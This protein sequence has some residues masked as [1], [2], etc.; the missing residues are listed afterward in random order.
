MKELRAYQQSEA[1]KMCAEKIQEKKIKKGESAGGRL[2][3]YCSVQCWTC[4]GRDPSMERRHMTRYT[5]MGSQCC[6]VARV[7]SLSLDERGLTEGGVAVAAR[8]L[9]LPSSLLHQRTRA[10]G[11]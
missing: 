7:G 1:Y 6:Q 10:P 3:G 2:C 8:R 11:S 5:C 9:I 4:P